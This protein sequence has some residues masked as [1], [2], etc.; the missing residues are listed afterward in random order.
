M[1]ERRFSEEE[2]A[3]ILKYATE[4]QS[5]QSSVLPAT[6]GLTLSELTEIGREV[7]I[8]PEALQVAAR[9]FDR[10]DRTTRL[11]LGLPIG[12]G[13]TIELDR[14]LTD[15]E[16]DRLVADLRE[17]FDAKGVVRT[18]GS[19][20]SWTNGNLQALLEPGAN[21][22]RLRL[23]TVRGNA[24]AMMGAGI[25]MFAMSALITAAA[26][27]KGTILDQSFITSITMVGGMGIAAFGFGAIGLPGWAR[28]RRRQMDDVAERLDASV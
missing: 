12:V 10:S 28:L 5:S 20:R 4:S 19:L 27:F 6:R 13:R 18:E 1:S 2:V 16:W 8:A 7:G 9:R 14:K 21:G 17:T 24:Q 23:R 15:E 25:M 3:E 26:A 22:H 11:F